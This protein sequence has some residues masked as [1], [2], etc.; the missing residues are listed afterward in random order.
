MRPGWFR[1]RSP[2]SAVLSLLGLA[3]ALAMVIA[4]RMG[5]RGTAENRPVQGLVT[6]IDD[7]VFPNRQVDLKSLTRSEEIIRV[8]TGQS[9]P[10]NPG[11]SLVLETARRIFDA[12]LVYVQDRAGVVV[13]CT[14]YEGGKTLTGNSYAF[15]PYFVSALRGRESVYP[16]MGVTTRQ[17]GLYFSTPIAPDG[18]GVVGVL[19]VK[20]SLEGI[21]AI[22]AAAPQ[23]VF[24]VSPDG[25]VFA[26]NRKD[27]LFHFVKPMNAAELERIRASQQFADQELLPLPNLFEDKPSVQFQGERWTVSRRPVLSDWTLVALARGAPAYV[28]TKNIV[29]TVTGALVAMLVII[30]ALAYVIRAR[31]KAEAA[32]RR[33]EEH[34]E[35]L[36]ERRTTELREA[37]EMAEA[38]TEAKSTFLASMSHELR[39][40]LNAILGYAQLLTRR[41]AD[42]E[43]R[44][45]LQ[46]IHRAG[47]H[48]LGLI[49]HVLSLSKIEAGKLTLD[50][51]PFS[52]ELFFKSIEDLTR[53]RAV[54]KGLDFHLKVQKPFPEALVG[55]SL[56]LRQVLVN[57]LGNAMKFTRQGSVGLRVERSGPMVRFAVQDTGPGMSAEEVGKLFQAFQQTQSGREAAEGTGLGL[58]IS[59][60]MVRLMGGVIEV[61]SEPG[62]GSVF[63]FEI[64]M[65]EDAVPEAASGQPSL[66]LLADHP[67]LRMLVVDDV[68]DNRTLLVR[69]LTAMGM[70]VR[71]AEDGPTALALW[72]AWQPHALWMDLRMPGMDGSEAARRLRAREAELGRPRTVVIALTASVLDMERDLLQESRFDGLMAKPFPESELMDMLHRHCGLGIA[73]SAPAPPALTEAEMTVRVEGLDGPWVRAFDQALLVGDRAEAQELLGL[74]PDRALAECFFQQLKEFQFEALRRVIASGRS[75][76]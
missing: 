64:P 71:E 38:A 32:L 14:Q 56:K 16:A 52:T 49:N 37:K 26:S 28:I 17:R 18:R 35:E 65:A 13:S 30:V 10:D 43:S 19:V 44:D 59:Q 39:T 12:E 42:P 6:R 4:Y 47:E 75:H 74:I 22:L 33:S 9:R 20:A 66:E 29:V 57:L 54:A 41:V 76:A 7:A 61:E 73:R 53:I 2:I 40:P 36:V 58:H 68:E 62:L 25:V 21:D 27:L 31:E 3:T 67:S 51:Q 69:M 15:R 45:N 1:L 34:L 23:P 48:L 24:L 55:D 50:F 70:E 72:E 11:V 8:A 63:R 60:A 46:R 5:V